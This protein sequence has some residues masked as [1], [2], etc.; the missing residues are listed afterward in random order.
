[1]KRFQLFVIL[2]T[3]LVAA[4]GSAT[5]ILA[6]PPPC[7]DNDGDGYPACDGVCD[8]GGKACDFDDTDPASHPGEL[9]GDGIDNDGDNLKLEP[10]GNC[11]AT[12][13]A[14]SV[15][16]KFICVSAD[17]NN[18]ATPPLVKLACP[19]P[20]ESDAAGNCHDG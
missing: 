9:C 1:M 13:G 14:C 16:S 6:D 8:P 11:T 3:F 19:L 12:K 10:G 17:P 5:L 4:L 20:A 7:P 15:P 18:P 2:V